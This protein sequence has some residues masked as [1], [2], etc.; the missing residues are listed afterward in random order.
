MCPTKYYIDI[1]L[2]TL[3]YYFLFAATTMFI[4]TS[5]NVSFTHALPNISIAKT[6][7]NNI[8]ITTDLKYMQN[9]STLSRFETFSN[10][11]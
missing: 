3:S 5:S 2:F 9:N 7:M 4:D 8:T 1:R 10:P 6:E 11:W